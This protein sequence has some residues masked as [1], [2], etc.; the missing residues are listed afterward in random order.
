MYQEKKSWLASFNVGENNYKISYDV[1]SG[2]DAWWA[3]QMAVKEVCEKLAF[4]ICFVE[5]IPEVGETI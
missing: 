1:G 4:K 2:E 3:A 5:P